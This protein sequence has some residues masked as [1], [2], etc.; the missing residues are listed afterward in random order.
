MSGNPIGVGFIGT[1]R[2]SDLH[3]IEYLQSTEARIV[4]LADAE[5]ERARERAAAW[6]LG[7][8]PVFADYRALL[9]RSDVDM[10]EILVPHHLH[11]PIAQAAFAAGK[12][13]SLQ[14]PM[15]LSLA[16]A[17]DLVARADA[18]GVAFKVF[19]N[20]LF[21]PPVVK[22]KELI[23]AGAIGE[24][25]TIRI[26]ANKGDPAYAWQVPASATA[27]RQDASRSGGSPLTFDDGHHKFALAWHFMGQ[28]EE[29][30]AWIGETR[31]D[32]GLVLDCPSL[33]SFRFPGGRLGNLEIVYSKDLQVLTRHY[34]MDDRIE[35]T[36]SRGVLWV[37]RGHGRLG[38][39]APVILYADGE[40]RAYSD[41]ET[42]WETSFVHSTRHFIEALRAGSPP[43][44]TGAEG[45][46]ILRFAL[47]AQASAR[48][49]RAVRLGEL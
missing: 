34:A 31:T 17:D 4:A 25:L 14:K 43:K 24:P 23:G 42:G 5:P 38:D 41:L 13:V 29:V 44:L 6:R 47:A 3:A 48:E 30:H 20:F 16:E 8:V 18:A 7:E 35:I 19:E 27:W 49:G 46:E 26:K 40:T 1:G 11:G 28:A 9:E 37:T 21:Y 10:V 2:I 22:A 33:I 15:T 12:H 36:G 32:D 39:A 45:R